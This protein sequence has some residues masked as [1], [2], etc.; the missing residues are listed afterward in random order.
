M[1]AFLKGIMEAITDHGCLVDVNGV[2]YEV[3]MPASQISRLPALGEPVTLY[4]W[5]MQREDGVQLFGFLAPEDRGLFKLLLGVTAVGPKSALAVL[6]ALTL[7]QLEDV[8]ARQDTAALSRIPGIGR[9]TSER[10]L[11]E[12][13][14]KLKTPAAGTPVLPAAEQETLAEALEALA[15]LGYSR[16]QA[17]QA[18]QKVAAEALPTG[19]SVEARLAE[20]VRRALRFL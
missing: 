10:L 15:A 6:S 13:K 12:L 20:W 19:H 9:K 8:V 2:G 3:L 18:L 11:L 14:D 1:I 5:H 16:V 17:R 4:T 7:A